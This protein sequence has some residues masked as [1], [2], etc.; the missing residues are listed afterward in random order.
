MA[1]GSSVQKRR[2][3]AA[4]KKGGN[5]KLRVLFV[6]HNHPNV[7]PGGAEGYALQVYGAMRDSGAVEPFFLARYGATA[8]HKPRPHPG[9]PFSVVGGDDNQYFMYTEGGDFDSF[10]LT[11]RNKEIYTTHYRDFLL[12][13]QPQVVHF[14]HTHYMGHDLLRQTRNTLPGVPIVY[15]LHEYHSICHR[16]GVMVRTVD[17][18][19]CVKASPRRCH[20]CFPGIAPQEFFM[21][22]RFLQS[23]FEEV[24]RFLAPSQFLLDRYVEWGIPPEKVLYHDHGLIQRDPVGEGERSARN[25]L[26]FFGQFSHYKGV[27]VLLHAMKILVKEQT[28]ADSAALRDAHLWF[29][30]A[31]LEWQSPDFQE[32][33]KEL[34]S[35]MTGRVTW[36]GK[37]EEQDIPRLMSEIDWVVV[38]SNW[39]ENSPRVIQEA[40]LY[41]RPVICSGIGALAEKVED[42]V[43]GLHFRAGDPASLAATLRRA[44]TTPGLWERLRHGIPTMR[45]IDQDVA[46]LID[47]YQKLMGGRRSNGRSR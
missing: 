18:E 22:Q 11:L 44:V 19:P 17:E 36:V 45:S 39:W 32:E 5:R 2:G 20:E 40:F 30:G 38:P 35:G 24:D 14:Q 29:H 23:H 21:R 27:D 43:S 4:R 10:Y 6:C 15:S 41:G 25:R 26:A 3:K 46:V 28:S 33:V 9:T 31:N 12:A 1:V 47:L 42:E 8:T 34:V 16:D 37:Y 13:I 7:Y